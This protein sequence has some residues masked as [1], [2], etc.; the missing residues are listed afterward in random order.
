MKAQTIN[1]ERVTR[2]AEDLSRKGPTT[3]G[4]N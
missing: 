4:L 1:A 3:S 2:K